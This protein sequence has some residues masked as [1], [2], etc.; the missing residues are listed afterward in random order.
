MEYQKITNL[1]GSTSD[2]VPRFITKKSIEVDTR[3]PLD[4]SFQGANR[5]FVVAFDNIN[6]GDGKVKRDSHRKYFLPRVDITNYNVLIDDRNF[7]DQPTND[8]ITRYDEIRKVATAKGDDY[9]TGCFLDYAYF[10]DHYQLIAVN[11]SKQKESDADP[12]AIQQIDFYV[13][14]KTN[15]Q[16]C[17]V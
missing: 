16:V 7:Y 5:L 11:L 12:R 1:L 14:L 9:T 2:K 4:V 8:Q 6:N 13:M 17:K 10:K 3:F 15:S